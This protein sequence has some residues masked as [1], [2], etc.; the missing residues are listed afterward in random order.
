MFTKDKVNGFINNYT[1]LM[2]LAQYSSV[3]VTH[4]LPTGLS[5]VRTDLF[6]LTLFY[7]LFLPVV[8][9]FF[10]YKLAVLFS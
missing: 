1:I 6:E 3:S 8:L 2:N 9:F 10:S 5:L 4:I 7:N